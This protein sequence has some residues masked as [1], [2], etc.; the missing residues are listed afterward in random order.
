MTWRL[1]LVLVVVVGLAVRV[2]YVFLYRRHITPSGDAFYFHY[3]ADLLASGKGFIDPYS[4]FWAR[5]VVP[6]AT[7]P[8]LWTLVLAL[9]AALGSTTFFAQL[10]WS[11]VIGALSV[12]VVA[13]AARE[14]AGPRAG[15]I[16]A[17]ITALY[18]VFLIDDGSLLAETLVVPLVAL[19]VWAFFRLWH[20][21]SLPRAALLGALCAL[22]ALTRSELVLLVVFLALP[23]GLVCRARSWRRRL[24]MCG[25]ALVGALCMFAPWWAYT[26]PRFSHTE[27]L[28][29][30][31][32][33]T[34]A[35]ANCNQ[36]YSGKLLGY[37]YD[38]CEVAILTPKAKDAS[39]R[40]ADLRQEAIHYVEHH[41]GR[42]PAVVGA[43][44]GRALGLFRPGQEIDLEWAVLGRPRLPA[45]IGLGCYYVLAVLGVAG[46][47]VLRGRRLPLLPFAVILSEVVL[48]SAVI[49]GQTRYRTPLDVGL[50][51]LSAV[52]I[53]RFID[54][55][56]LRWRRAV[57]RASARHPSAP[58]G[59]NVLGD[60]SDGDGG[61][62]REGAGV[63]IPDA[64]SVG[65]ASGPRGV[66]AVTTRDP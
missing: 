32:G 10:L 60:G 24:A 38:P 12:A 47:V 5:Q 64:Q 2:G 21:P 6:G 54:L 52:A 49:F 18:P 46:A 29:D 28:S 43:R 23:A 65:S 36:T 35:S 45:A 1:R 55:R 33:V 20:R 25:V 7:H 34:L 9:A 40:D 3:Q 61:V 41:A 13:M 31:L 62:D 50:V 48:V 56:S 27:L 14:V 4:L 16:A 30:Q 51:I 15:L 17:G 57:Q 37:W 26:V 59:A 66:G 42:V 11:C 53:D 63:A 39:V 8:P 44:V 19:V 58:K 22:C